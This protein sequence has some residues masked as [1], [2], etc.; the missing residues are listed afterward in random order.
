MASLTLL[1]GK[2]PADV[3]HITRAET[4]IGKRADCDIVLAGNYVSKIH[5]RILRHSDGLYIEDLKSTN[6]TQVG[7]VPVETPRRLVDGD[8][9]KIGKFRLVFSE[10]DDFSEAMTIVGSLDVCTADGHL[11]LRH[12]AEQKLRVIMEINRELIGQLDLDA[13][14]H[15]VL[16][17]LLRVFPHAERG[18][19]L[20]RDEVTDT[21]RLK[22]SRFR[23]ASLQHRSP[24]RMVCNYVLRQGNVILCDNVSTSMFTESR[25]LG[26]SQVTSIICAPLVDRSRRPVGV[27]QVDTCN[28]K[29]RFEQADL[30][31]LA[32]LAGTISVAVESARMHELELSRRRIEQEAEDA[33]SVQRNFLPG[34]CPDVP[35]YQFWHDYKPARF[36]GGDYFD[37]RAVPCT[38]A[39][40]SGS[41]ARRWAVTLGD[42]SGKGMPA[43][44][45]MARIAAEVRMLLQSDS[46]LSMIAEIL[47]KSLYESGMPDRFMTLLMLLIDPE[48]HRLTIINAGHMAPL[49]RRSGGEIE[50]VGQDQA[51]PPLGVE[52]D[53]AYAAAETS[54]GPGDVVLLYTDGVN[55]ALSPQ[56]EQ[57]GIK[58]LHDC[59]TNASVTAISAGQAIQARL[60]T[61]TSGRDQYDDMAII[62]FGRV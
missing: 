41:Q 20:V 48:W 31:F 46:K 13:V 43:A 58:R 26:D 28:R 7:G 12:R 11:F 52:K 35:G 14:L 54:I 29:E 56:G 25:S 16:D 38:S 36:V 42:V 53:Q 22:A 19:V 62:C 47:S 3:F 61:H 55:E 23:R 37:Y 57:F 27:I 51:G 18:F 39:P 1:P 30:E 17:E 40:A 44:L 8:E 21:L 6:T 45:L 49:I 33:W 32:A 50:I 2:S 5:A 24:S 15:K 34:D 4:V 60:A 10:L 59:L 9:I